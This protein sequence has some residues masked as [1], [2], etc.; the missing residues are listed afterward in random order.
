MKISEMTNDQACEAIIRISG[1]LAN[2]F[3]DEGASALSEDIDKI[4]KGEITLTS[5]M[6]TV[7]P[8]FVTFGI[9]NHKDDLYEFVGALTGK[10]I[11]EVA[12]MNFI[13]TI[14]TVRDSWDEVASGFFT[15]TARAEKK[16]TEE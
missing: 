13:E 9:K 15:S 1:A 11:A 12:N 8:R 16:N 6:S 10:N 7:I 14:N 2:I 5:A 3:E 4:G